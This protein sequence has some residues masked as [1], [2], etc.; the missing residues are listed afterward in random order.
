MGH[1]WN[2]YKEQISLVLFVCISVKTVIGSGILRLE[3]VT[4]SVSAAIM[5]AIQCFGTAALSNL[6]G[7]TALVTG[8][9]LTAGTLTVDTVGTAGTT[10]AAIGFYHVHS[11]LQ[12]AWDHYS[13]RP[14]NCQFIK[15]FVEINHR[16]INGC[17][18]GI[19]EL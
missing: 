14:E 10:L 17:L 19:N 3:F 6:T 4:G 13:I 7:R 16:Q 5:A 15:C 2:L 9:G 12:F 1:D 8:T 18:F 11:P